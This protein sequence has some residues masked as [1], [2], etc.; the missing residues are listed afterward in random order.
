MVPSWQ[1]SSQVRRRFF[2]RL[3][4]SPGVQPKVAAILWKLSQKALPN[5]D[6]WNGLLELFD[7]GTYNCCN[8]NSEHSSSHIFFECEFPKQ[9]WECFFVWFNRQHG[10]LHWLLREHDLVLFGSV[11][12][13][14]RP[15]SKKQWWMVAWSG[16]IFE[17]WKA[18]TQ[19]IYGEEEDV[20]VGAIL[21]RAWARTTL[22]GAALKQK[23]VKKFKRQDWEGAGFLLPGSD[24]WQPCAAWAQTRT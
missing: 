17:L 7:K 20:G 14:G 5:F 3:W 24:R 8:S 12:P 1:V 11:D 23:R 10:A 13:D 6:R 19:C 9:V 2:E 18:W 15:P 22:S 21:G 4:S 16:I